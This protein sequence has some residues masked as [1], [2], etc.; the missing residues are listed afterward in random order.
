MLSKGEPAKPD[1]ASAKS[2]QIE[3]SDDEIEQAD[4]SSAYSEAVYN[5][6]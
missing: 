5:L 2:S 6:G 3:E 1:G 4:N